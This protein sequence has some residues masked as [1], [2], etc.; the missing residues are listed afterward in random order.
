MIGHI[1]HVVLTVHD[2]ERAV[3]FYE[4]MLGLEPI[5]FAG[6]RRALRFGDNWGGP[7]RQCGQASSL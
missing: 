6:N 3:A 1:D 7:T 2:V 4:R 5:T